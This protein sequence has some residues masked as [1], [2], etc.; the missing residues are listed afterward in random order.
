MCWTIWLCPNDIVF[1]QS[2]SNSYL[3]V[4]F[5]GAYWARFCSLLSEEEARTD[6]RENCQR[7]EAMMMELFARNERNFR[8]SIAI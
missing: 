7:L 5:G 4:I 8:R 2:N 6:L 1:H 3:Q